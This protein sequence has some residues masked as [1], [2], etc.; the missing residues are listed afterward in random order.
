MKSLLKLLTAAL[1]ALAPALAAAGGALPLNPIT[2]GGFETAVPGRDLACSYA[3]EDTQLRLLRD[4]APFVEPTDDVTGLG[5]SNAVHENW[6]VTVWPCEQGAFKAVGWSTDPSV[7]FRDLDG[8]GDREARLSPGGGSHRMWQSF[9]HAPQA[10]SGDFDAFRFRVESA[11]GLPAG[12]AVVIS[13]STSPGHA[14]HPWVGIY[15]ECGLYLTPAQLLPG[16]NG[17]RSADPATGTL[18][19]YARDGFCDKQ[20]AAWGA[21]SADERRA[22][23]AGMRIVQVSFWGFPGALVLDDVEITG[24]RLMTQ[25]TPPTPPALPPVPAPELPG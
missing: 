10:V 4:L 8:D 15:A 9:V 7:Q 25:A 1:L 19:D 12:S 14:T 6:L 16:A 23:L 2:N 24:A 20:A 22:L 13:F 17:L 11:G 21:A 3:G 5:L 18:R